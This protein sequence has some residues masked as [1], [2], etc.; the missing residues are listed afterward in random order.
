MRIM[1]EFRNEPLR[2]DGE[3]S[4]NQGDHAEHEEGTVAGPGGLGRVGRLVLP[5][6]LRNAEYS[7]SFHSHRLSYDEGPLVRP[8]TLRLAKSSYS[9]QS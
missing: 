4:L 9:F 3:L 8:E 5:D 6:V 1:E 7:N 2:V